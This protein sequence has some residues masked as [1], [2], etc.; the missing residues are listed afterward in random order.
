MSTLSTSAV[1]DLAERRADDHAHGEIDDVALHRE[2]A[3]LR[4]HAHV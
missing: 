3:E 1:D 4:Q 2:C